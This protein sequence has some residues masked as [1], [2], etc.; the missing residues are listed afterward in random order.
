[1]KACPTCMGNFKPRTPA[2]VYCSLWCLPVPRK[3]NAFMPR[4]W[5]EA[6]KAAARKRVALVRQPHTAARR[7]RGTHVAHP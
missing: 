7:N 2:H 1:M 6:A 4:R 3:L 5:T